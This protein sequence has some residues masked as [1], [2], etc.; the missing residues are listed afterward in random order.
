MVRARDDGG[1]VDIAVGRAW[2]VDLTG[3]PLA[4]VEEG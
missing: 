4:E 1:R 2:S 3:R